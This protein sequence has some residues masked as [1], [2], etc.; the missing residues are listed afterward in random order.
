MR[1]TLEKMKAFLVWRQKKKVSDVFRKN[2]QRVQRGSRGKNMCLSDF[3]DLALHVSEPGF[4]PITESRPTR[5][6]SL[7]L[8]KRSCAVNQTYQPI[9]A[10]PSALAPFYRSRKKIQLQRFLFS[11]VI[12]RFLIFFLN[13]EFFL[14]TTLGNRNFNF[15]SSKNNQK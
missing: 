12:A 1:Q 3:P 13:P 11:L 8:G 9:S 10:R 6:G 15:F 14:E 5:S 4:N 7:R 2:Y